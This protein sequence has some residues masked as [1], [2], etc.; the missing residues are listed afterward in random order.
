MTRLVSVVLALL[1]FFD[2][3]RPMTPHDVEQSF[4]DRAASAAM[5]D[6]RLADTAL[7]HGN[8]AE[9]REFAQRVLAERS[10]A[11]QALTRAAEN[12]QLEL[13]P[14]L[15]EMHQVEYIRL[16][17]LR[18]DAFDSAYLASVIAAGES[19]VADCGQEM[20]H[21]H[22]EVSGWAAESLPGLERRIE[23]ARALASERPPS[24]RISAA[25]PE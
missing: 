5:L 1:A 24:V 9:V 3:Q 11:H 10:E 4:V 20:D 21:F 14:D 7:S 19:S 2:C 25:T 17:T 15:S 22:S 8:R 23:A 6:V 13:P 18:G 12:A 16:A